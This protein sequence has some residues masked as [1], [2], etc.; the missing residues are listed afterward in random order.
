M[1]TLRY[2]EFST[3]VILKLLIFKVYFVGEVQ[4]DNEP[5]ARVEEIDTICMSAIFVTYLHIVISVFHE[6]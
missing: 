4:W 2:I 3:V 1:V 5:Y 6:Q